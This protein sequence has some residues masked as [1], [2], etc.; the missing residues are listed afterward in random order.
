MM[1]LYAGLLFNVFSIT[2]SLCFRQGNIVY[3]R[4]PQEIQSQA[5]EFEQIAR[6]LDFLIISGDGEHQKEISISAKFKTV[7]SGLNHFMSRDFFL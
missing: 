6:V 1:A 5:E 3:S 2:L 4:L 7:W